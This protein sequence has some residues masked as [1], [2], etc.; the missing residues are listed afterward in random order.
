MKIQI[1]FFFLMNVSNI[2]SQEIEIIKTEKKDVSFRGI[3]AVDDSIV[4]ISGNKG[5]VGKSRDGGKTF[6]WLNPAKY[7]TRDF[8]DIEVFNDSTAI[9]MAIESPGII[10]K[11]INSGK[12]W[13]E[14]YKDETEGV[15][16]DAIYFSNEK[17]G[18]LLG[19]PLSKFP[20][21]LVSDDAGSSWKSLSEEQEL[22][23]L[24]ILNEGE[25]FFASSGTNALISKDYIFMVTGGTESNLYYIGKN[26]I[27]RKQIPIL[28]GKISQGANSIDFKVFPD[29]NNLG[30]IVGGDFNE[31]KKSKGNCMLFSFTEKGFD[32]F[33]AQ[34]PPRGYKSCVEILSENMVIACGTSGVD[35]SFDKG[36]NWEYISKESFHTLQKSK[37]GNTVFFAGANGNFGKINFEETKVEEPILENPDETSEAGTPENSEKKEEKNIL[38]K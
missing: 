29:K 1:L 8:R 22:K 35:A 34:K 28:Q 30:V 26:K 9:I 15:F 18:I 14:V 20:Y 5:T 17:N 3:Y 21:F 25:S 37:T 13:K 16:F 31:P 23:L 12:S 19:D 4:W 2:I 24:P 36:M 6:K 11:T 27:V 38:N 10:L 33:E 32:F 7:E